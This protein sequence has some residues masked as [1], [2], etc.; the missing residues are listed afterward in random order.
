[1]SSPKYDWGIGEQPPLLDAHSV[2]KHDVLRTYVA[3]YIEVLTSNPRRDVLRLTLI[4]GFAGGGQYQRNGVIV[5]GSP[6]ILLD[7]LAAAQVRVNIDRT[8]PIAI[9]NDFIFV[10]REKSNYDYLLST[11]KASAHSKLTADKISVLHNTF[12]SALPAIIERIQSRGRA[13][14]SIF[15]LDQ[16][17]YNNVSFQAVRT[18]LSSLANPEIILT[19]NVDFLIDYLSSDE[20]FLKGVKPVELSVQQIQ[21]MLAMKSQRE[22]RWLIQ[23]LLYRHLIEQTGAPFYTPFFIKSTESHKAYWLVHI[24]KHPKAR[25]EMAALHWNIQ[26]HFVH[27]GQ[28]GLRMLGFDPD[29]AIDQIP[30]DF[31]FDDNARARSEKALMDELPVRIFRSRT[32]SDPPP[33]LQSLFT[34]VC[35]ET[36]ATTQL[37]STALVRLRDERE[38]EIVTKDGR[39]KPR[40]SKID[41]TDVVLPAKQRDLFSTMAVPKS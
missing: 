14:R 19:F 28:A 41:W 36:P 35:N 21:S 1:M 31:I 2:A 23:N 26:N 18:I 33:T 16:F 30:L 12:E 32:L 7:E 6:L 5:P 25:D 40:T 24:S 11:I 38:I 4:D 10:E 22:A 27:H 17:G 34:D 13:H 29:Q 20:S 15:F 39:P 9:A 37:V 8:K 3:R